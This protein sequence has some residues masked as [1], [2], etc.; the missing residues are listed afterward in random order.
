MHLQIGGITETN[1]I[2]FLSACDLE[3]IFSKWKPADRF[4]FNYKGHAVVHCSASFRT[5]RQDDRAG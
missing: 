2:T 4:C 1:P 5:G 3:L